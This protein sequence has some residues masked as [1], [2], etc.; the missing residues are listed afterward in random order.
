MNNVTWTK[1]K[2][3]RN[4]KGVTDACGV[5]YIRGSKQDYCRLVSKDYTVHQDF[6]FTVTSAKKRAESIVQLAV[7]QENKNH[8]LYNVFGT[9]GRVDRNY[10]VIANTMREAKQLVR[11][12][13]AEVKIVSA[14]LETEKVFEE[15]GYPK[16]AYQ[17][18]V[19]EALAHKGIYLYDEGT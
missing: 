13:D 19:S 14:S 7:A 15:M 11:Q 18:A 9:Y 4:W 10:H 2:G 5:F 17:Q 3:R 6:H 1:M 12:T 8:K 16:G